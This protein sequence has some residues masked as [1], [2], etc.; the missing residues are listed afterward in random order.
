MSILKKK[1][2]H[3]E[4]ACREAGL[5]VT[6]QRMEVFREL[7]SADDHP[8]AETLYHRLQK[9][10][11]TLS[12]D[13]V[14]RTLTTFEDHDMISRV[15]TTESH[16]RFEAEI[17]HHHHA[18]CSLCNK[19]TDFQWDVCDTNELPENITKWGQ[20]QNKQITLTGVCSDCAKTQKNVR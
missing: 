8:T 6:H 12:L 19:I 15:Q 11:P 2:K 17:E 18:I 9:T 13:T 4:T 5:K 10:L 20:I 1:L 7:A 3:F 16:A 14:Y